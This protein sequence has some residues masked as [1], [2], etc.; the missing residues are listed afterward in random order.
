MS[1]ARAF[2][3]AGCTSTVNSLWRADDAARSS[4]LIQFHKYPE[5]GYSKSRALQLAK[6]DYIH[7]GALHTSPD[8]WLNLIVIGNTDP[9]YNRTRSLQ[10]IFVWIFA[11]G[12]VT[13]VVTAGWRRR[14]KKSTVSKDSGF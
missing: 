4:I 14:K 5:E 2:A 1:F 9:L 8:Y 3:Y 7:S 12:S 11:L 10:I 6:V 13:V